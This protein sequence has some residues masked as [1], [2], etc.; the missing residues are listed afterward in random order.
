MSKFGREN[1]TRRARAFKTSDINKKYS[2]VIL[3]A[4]ASARVPVR[5]AAAASAGVRARRAA[6]R[7]RH[8]PRLRAG[9]RP[10][11]A[12]IPPAVPEG[13]RGYSHEICPNNSVFFYV[14]LLDKG[15]PFLPPLFPILD[16][17]HCHLLF[18]MLNDE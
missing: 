15:H 17:Q 8:V 5:E 3:L 12:H 14:A 16:M 13:M 1:L 10:V 18:K 6:R 7:P 4:G 2:M 9:S 11:R